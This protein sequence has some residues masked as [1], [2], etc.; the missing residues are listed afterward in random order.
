MTKAQILRDTATRQHIINLQDLQHHPIT[1]PH[2][3]RD[4]FPHPH[5][6]HPHLT[7]SPSRSLS[8]NDTI[9]TTTPQP[10]PPRTHTTCF[11]AHRPTSAPVAPRL[12][13][14]HTHT[15][16]HIYGSKGTPYETTHPNPNTHTPA[17]TPTPDTGRLT[18]RELY[19]PK[20]PDTPKVELLKSQLAPSMSLYTVT[21]RLTLHPEI[22]RHPTSRNSQKSA[23][24]SMCLYT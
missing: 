7:H 6:P 4:S 2:T 24:S 23:C 10:P 19:T 15:P 21:I 3:P 18:P 5:H 8:R 14:S 13:N 17:P 20:S 9:P 12:H 1:R 11:P 22:H 16:R